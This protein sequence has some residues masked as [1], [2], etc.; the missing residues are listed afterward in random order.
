M[1][2]AIGFDLGLVV[3]WTVLTGASL[4]ATVALERLGLG[5]APEWVRLFFAPVWGLVFLSVMMLVS[6]ALRALAGPLVPGNY[7][8]PEH[9]MAKR[10]GFHLLNQRVVL[11]GPYRELIFSWHALRT[12]YFWTVRGKAAF[13]MKTGANTLVLDA[14]LMR[15][16]KGSMVASN[17]LVAGH[18]VEGGELRLGHV[19]IQA[20]AQVMGFCQIGPHVTIEADAVI[21]PSSALIRNVRIG[22][23]AYL[24]AGCVCSPGVDVGADAV[25][26]HSVVMEANVKIGEGA[27]VASYARLSEG[28]VVAP[29]SKYRAE[30]K[31]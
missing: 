30:P 19:D 22:S 31:P 4:A 28:T 10:W 20:G 15:F 6:G 26:G 24:G 8:F 12:L 5:W 3:V 25:V 1:G 17:T 9:P 18:F 13:D 14:P 7:P 11:W 16:G 27:V 29:F 21:G 2:A 23:G